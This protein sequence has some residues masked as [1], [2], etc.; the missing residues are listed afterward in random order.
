MDRMKILIIAD[1]EWNDVVFGN[2]VLTNWFTDFDA[3]F[4][5]IYCS[6]G[7]PYNNVCERYFQLTDAQMGFS[8]FTTQRAGSIVVKPTDISSIEASKKN[9]QR[10]GMYGFMKKLSLWMHTPI[11]M[12]RD[13]IWTIGRYNKSALSQ[14]VNDF[15]PDIIFCP[16]YGTPKLWR[17][18]RYIHSLCGAPMIAFTGDDETSYKQISYSP[19]YWFRRWYC[20]QSFKKT[21]GIFSH[22][23]MHSKDQAK[24]YTNEFGIT[25]SC[26]F[27]CGV[28]PDKYEKKTVGSPIRLVY[29]GRLYCNRWKSLAAIGKAL[30][31][32][33]KNGV[34]MVLDIYTQE[35]LTKESAKYL[36]EDNYIYMKG[37]VS[38]SEL[39]RIYH[40]ADIALHVESFDKKY[41]YATRVSFSTK[42]IDL[43]A[44]T[45]AIIA[46][47]WNEQ[48]GYQYLK[49]HDAAICIDSYDRILP[50]LQAIVENPVMVQEYA[51]KAYEC[52]KTNHSRAIIQNQLKTTF[53]KYINK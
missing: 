30:C 36:I 38:S 15:V 2:G 32:I 17:L 4:A 43:M 48:T 25:T 16:Q 13:I 26:L 53:E 22:Y 31:E 29:A 46:I 9:A 42:I 47:C 45:C 33:N 18:E 20:R 51:R 35:Q 24:D 19:L 1:E 3:T 11:M 28:F 21:V 44:S 5:E 12:I 27:K 40:D 41:K 8:M 49:E 52:G 14:F 34:K 50:Q 39:P 6:P 37:S 7:L 23:M 10:R